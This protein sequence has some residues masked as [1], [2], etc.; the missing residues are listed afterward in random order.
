MQRRPSPATLAKK[1]RGAT[2]EMKHQS[3]RNI[4]FATAT[5]GLAAL[6]GRTSARIERVVS[7]TSLVKLRATMGIYNSEIE[8]STSLGGNTGQQL[9]PVK[10]SRV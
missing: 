4:P 7:N 8:K 10:R 2:A 1:L 6:N 5:N 9:I 3:K